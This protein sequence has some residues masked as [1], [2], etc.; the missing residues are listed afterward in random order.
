[1]LPD[2]DGDGVADST[3]EFL[4]NVP[5]TQGFM[6]ANGSLY[7]QN[8]PTILS[9]PFQPGDRVPSG[10]SQTI[11]TVNAPQDELHWTKVM[12]IAQDGTIYVT[13]GGSQDDECLSTDPTRGS[14]WAIVDAGADGAGTSLVAKGFRNPIAMRCESDH[15]VC[16]AVELGLDYSWYHYGREKVVPVRAGDNWGFPCCATQNTAYEGTVYHDTGGAPDC[17]AVAAESDSF[18][19]GQ[20]PFGLDFEPGKWPAPW[21][22]R[23]FVTLHGQSGSWTGARIAAT[24]IDPDSGA[25]HSGERPRRRRRPDLDPDAQLGV[26]RRQAGSRTPGADRVRPRR[27][28]V[29]R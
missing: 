3:I 2:D 18:V 7:Y 24:G 23:V 28:R 8:G 26:G 21:T 19:I 14:I 15:N 10:Q 11:T 1:M 13:N 17:G 4:S 16:L 12:D 5:S 25:P 29:R 22:G 6:F 27:P 9:V 20:T